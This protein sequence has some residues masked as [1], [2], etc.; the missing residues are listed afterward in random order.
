MWSG[1]VP[2][3]PPMILIKFSSK[4]S[5]IWS[6]ISLGV[7]SYCPKAFGNPALGCAEILKDVLCANCFKYGFSWCA[8]K[9]QLKPTLNNGICEIEIKKASTVCPESV[10]PEASVMVPETIIGMSILRSSLTSSMAKSAAFAFSVSKMVSTKS[11]S[12][13]PSIRASTCC[14]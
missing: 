6:C 1:F 12:T 5:L 2:Q 13:P 4:Y 10:L 9:A 8:P 11:K 14:L 7:S 3:H